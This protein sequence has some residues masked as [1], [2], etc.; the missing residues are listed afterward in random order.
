MTSGTGPGDPMVG[1]LFDTPLSSSAPM[2][3]YTFLSPGT[4]PF[5]C[6]PHFAMG[7]TGV[8]TVDELVSDES[9]SWGAIKS[10][11]R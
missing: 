3:S 9:E 1:T 11:F 5:F 7:M 10:L 6:R 4:V 2:F 8:I